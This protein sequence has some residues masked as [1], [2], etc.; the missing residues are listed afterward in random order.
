[1]SK[2]YSGPRYTSPQT[3]FSEADSS[4]LGLPLTRH[5]GY[6]N[7]S[8]L[9]PDQR[10]IRDIQCAIFSDLE[11][12]ITDQDTAKISEM[13]SRGLICP[14]ATY[15]GGETPLILAIERGHAGVV[16][17]LVALGADVD[18][19]ASYTEKRRAEDKRFSYTVK[20]RTALQVAAQTGNLAVVKFLV[21]ECRADDAIIAP[22]GQMALRL[23]AENGH[24]EVVRYLPARRGGGWRR[25]RTEHAVA[26]RRARKAG[27]AI[28]KGVKLMFWDLPY[29]VFF[30][31]P[32]KVLVYAWKNRKDL[33]EWC[34]ELAKRIPRAAFRAVK[35][36]P[37]TVGRIVKWLWRIL[38]AAPGRIRRA[39]ELIGAWI[40]KVVR[41]LGGAV[42]AIVNR[43]FSVLH[44]VVFGMLRFFRDIT[45]Q[46]VWNGFCQLLKAVFMG[47][48]V[49]IL[50]GIAALGGASYAA[51][52]ALLGIFGWAIW[53]TIRVIWHIIQ[54]V[55]HKTLV[56]LAAFG[57]SIAK[58]FREMM[59]LVNPK[60]TC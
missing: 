41:R 5:P 7:T 12:A 45:L 40:A 48:P 17:H 4:I 49:A 51:V 10:A 26:M 34:V 33:A 8:D 57:R 29:F 58:G 24:R 22:D 46:D 55:P 27:K 54:Y 19:L 37:R 30:H 36:F 59:V 47:L 23:A 16:R 44:T 1:M 21:E 18:Q 25:W 52:K 42:A 39:G 2:D 15:S 11:R 35:Q 9:A 60:W 50:K 6:S 28:A 32:K 14:S 20:H 38:K 56:I 53:W 3:P 31:A 13:V 43:L